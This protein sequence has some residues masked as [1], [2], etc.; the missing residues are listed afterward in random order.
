MRGWLFSSEK[1]EGKIF[2]DGDFQKALEAGWVESP[3][4]IE[5]ELPKRGPG[6]PKKETS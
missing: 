6:R 5:A 2:E 1:P 4:L 3:A